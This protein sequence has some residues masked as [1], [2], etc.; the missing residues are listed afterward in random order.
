MGFAMSMA[1]LGYAAIPTVESVEKVSLPAD[2]KVSMATL[3]PDG[4]KAIVTSMTGI[5]LQLLDLSTG[6]ITEVSPSGSGMDVEFSAD[7][8]N[9]VYRESSYDSNHRRFVALKSFDVADGSTTTLVAPSRNLQG[10]VV[11]GN[12]AVAVENGRKHVK[13]LGGNATSQGRVALSISQGRLFVTE[14]DGT[15]REIRP[16]GNDCGSYLWQSVSPDGQ[17]IAAFGVGTGAFVCDLNGENVKLLGMYRAPQWLDNE[18][19]VAMDDRDNGIVT[20]ESTIMAINADGSAKA[21]LTDG[22]VVALFPTPAPGKV[23]FTTPTGELYIIN[24]K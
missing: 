4:S 17:R 1:A 13:S 8:A 7:G 24:L 18:T 5:G 16:L 14:P 20:V 19:I 6:R 15:T 21:A 9:V 22:D 12:R 2:M 11:D 23:A 3:S 10:F